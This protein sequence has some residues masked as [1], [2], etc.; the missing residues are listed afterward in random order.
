MKKIW[1]EILTPKQLNFFEPMIHDLEKKHE[2]LVTTRKLGELDQLLKHSKLKW[3]SVGKYG[4]ATK[5]GK[6]TS[7]IDRIRKLKHIINDFK[8]DIA[9]SFTS[10]DA[11]Y[12]SFK[13]GIY[14][15]G[16]SDSPH[17]THV[18]K[19][20]LPLINKLVTPNVIAKKEF[21]QYGIDEKN[22]IQYRGIDAGYIIKSKK[23]ETYIPNKT[24]VYRMHESEASYNK[25]NDY[26]TQI[27]CIL[28]LSVIFQDHKIIVWLR[29][30]EK[31]N[32]AKKKNITFIRK[33]LPS[34][35]ILKNCSLFIGSGGTM[36]AEAGLLGIP[37][38]TYSAT[39]NIIEDY[40]VQK[41]LIVRETD[42]SK[43]PTIASRLLSIWYRL[44]KITLAQKELSRMENP[45][46][47]LEQLINK[48]K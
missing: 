28:K 37:T 18:M 21:T 40:L 29:S 30:K 38:I 5:Q 42:H 14:H 34:E 26:L 46:K 8:P 13:L 19:L 41:K 16:F 39:P 15:I 36:T 25:F 22:I 3:T 24:I 35:Q 48:V 10:P 27:V 43:I 33:S 12:V 32:M 47:K 2:I 11:S 7:S 31:P 20:S 17:A 6:L 1:F 9:V 44:R 23:P 4:G 45:S